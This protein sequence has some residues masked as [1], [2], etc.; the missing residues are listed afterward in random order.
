[1]TA[2]ERYI[3]TAREHGWVVTVERGN[4]VWAAR[5]NTGDGYPHRLTITFEDLKT[6]DAFL[7]NDYGKGAE[8]F[9]VGLRNQMDVLRNLHNPLR[10]KPFH[11][12]YTRRSPVRKS[13]KEMG[14]ITGYSERQI[15]KA[16]ICGFADDIFMDRMCV[17]L[18]GEHPASLYGYESWVSG[19]DI[20][21]P[22]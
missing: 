13:E 22:V 19:V 1:M 11:E 20:S 18:L 17:L 15:R 10:Y 14:V 6:T 9:K 2:K 4:T 7:W 3:E 5:E 16:R 21:E 8:R 12:A